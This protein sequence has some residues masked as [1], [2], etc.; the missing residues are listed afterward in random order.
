MIG[1]AKRL[2]AVRR[3]Y[4][5][6][7]GCGNLSQSAFARLCGINPTAWNNAETGYSNL[8]I[9]I[10]IKIARQTGVTLDYLFLGNPAGLPFALAVE[11]M[12][13]PPND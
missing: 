4:G 6:L 10:A 12:K 11:I 3:A 1:V 13:L 2:R 5:R 7:H 8:G 9:A